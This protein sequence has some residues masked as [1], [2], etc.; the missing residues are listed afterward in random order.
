MVFT[1]GAYAQ[2]EP[3]AKPKEV[4]LK[5]TVFALGGL[6]NLSY[7]SKTKSKPEALRF[8]SAYRSSIY[9]YRG[10]TT[11]SFY[12]GAVVEADSKPVAIYTVPETAK[13]QLLLFFPKTPV[14]ADGLKYEVYGVDDDA[15]KTP[16]GSFS[17]INVSGREYLAQ[18]KD[19]RITIP[20][21]VGP[22]HAAQG[23]VSLLLATQA[24]GN[25]TP[26]GRHI[27]SISEQ[28]RVTLIFYPPLS[29]SG[30][31]PI[32]RRLV[33]TLPPKETGMSGGVV[34]YP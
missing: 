9:T 17:T 34:Q 1:L 26:S 8:Y 15:D 30:V 10:T 22:A 19:D 28:D 23:R 7:I 6:E 27:F 20:K 18:Y 14:S 31:Y 25:W 12:E 3:M 16:A 13:Q 2:A 21:G 33:D 11:L 29:S 24:N 4:N 32:I 5:F